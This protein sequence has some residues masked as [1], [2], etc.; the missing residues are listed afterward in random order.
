MLKRNDKC[1]CGSGK[2]YKKCCMES[3]KAKAAKEKKDNIL[4]QKK[5]KADKLY[6]DSILKLSAYL[7]EFINENE[8][9]AKME[10]KTREDFF[11]DM[12]VRNIAANRFFA[13]YFSYDCYVDENNTPAMYVLKNKNFTKE[14]SN[15]VVNCIN[16]YPSLFEIARAEDKMVVIK[17]IFTGIEYN[18]LDSKILGDFEVGNYLLG[19]PVRI[20]DIYILIDL[21]IRIQEETKNVIYNTLM[22]VYNKNKESVPSIEYF[23]FINSLFFYKYML[24]LLQLSDYKDE[25]LEES[26][27]DMEDSDDKDVNLENEEDS[28]IKLLSD[29]VEDESALQGMIEIWNKI[30]SSANYK[31]FENG[32]AAGLE[33]YYRKENGIGGTQN[34][35]ANVYGVS[36]STLAKRNKEISALVCG[37]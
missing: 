27:N 29:N 32:W 22:D 10:E 31:G 35:V 3:D 18:T 1:H 26:L 7:E 5:E 11:D 9:F 30:S 21:T 6:T 24:Q 28:L 19:R 25:E 17:D 4:E 2:K 12:I 33:Y 14:E 16:S 37:K 8:E 15:I 13:S 36:T 20:G 34:A 23:V